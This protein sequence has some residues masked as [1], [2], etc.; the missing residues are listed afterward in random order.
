LRCD[1]SLYGIWAGFLFWRLS[2][3]WNMWQKHFGGRCV[4]A[5]LIAWQTSH[6]VNIAP[7]PIENCLIILL[8]NSNSIFWSGINLAPIKKIQLERT[9]FS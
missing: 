5:H 7:S 1:C 3:T 2:G 4:Y 9:I 8:L 6:T